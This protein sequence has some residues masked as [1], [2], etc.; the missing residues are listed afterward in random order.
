MLSAGNSPEI[1]KHPGVPFKGNG[2]KI[3][4]PHD[5]S[6]FITH[7][8]VSPDSKYL[9]SVSTDK[10]IVIYDLGSWEKKSVVAKGHTMGIYDVKWYDNEHVITCSAD[11]K[12]RVWAVKDGE[13]AQE[14]VHQL[15]Q[16]PT[17]EKKAQIPF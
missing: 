8:A 15:L 6:K 9:A 14:H 13:I 7:L 5:T 2:E 12:T 1:L 17:E 16:T 4:H 10:Q 11:N 3:A